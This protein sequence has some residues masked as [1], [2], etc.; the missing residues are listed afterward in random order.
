MKKISKLVHIIVKQAPV[1]HALDGG[2]H[3]TVAAVLLDVDIVCLP[4]FGSR[5]VGMFGGAC[6]KVPMS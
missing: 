3:Q 1:V 6:G 2:V 4:S 5:I